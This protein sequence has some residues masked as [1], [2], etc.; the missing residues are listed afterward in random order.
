[1]PCSKCQIPYEGY[2]CLRQRREKSLI[3]SEPDFL[4]FFSCLNFTGDYHC[5]AVTITTPA[6]ISKYHVGASASSDIYPPPRIRL[7]HLCL[8]SD[9]GSHLIS[10][11]LAHSRPTYPMEVGRYFGWILVTMPG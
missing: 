4:A 5:T 1:M 2:G 6:N 3:T 9:S 8:V 7:H 10:I 11:T